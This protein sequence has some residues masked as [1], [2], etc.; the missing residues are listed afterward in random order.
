L[1]SN[2]YPAIPGTKRAVGNRKN[3]CLAG[4]DEITS[5]ERCQGANLRYWTKPFWTQSVDKPNVRVSEPKCL[6][7]I[8]HS[9]RR[10]LETNGAHQAAGFWWILLPL[11]FLLGDHW[12]LSWLLPVTYRSEALILVGTAEGSRNYVA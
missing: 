8:N 6:V 12:S 1:E 2:D 4:L 3:S 7:N 11:F 9:T 5:Q 10:A